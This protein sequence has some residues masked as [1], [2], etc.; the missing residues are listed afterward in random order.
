MPKRKRRNFTPSLKWKLFLKH[1]MVKVR[2]WNC[3][4][5]ITSAKN[6]SQQFLEN[7]ASLFKLSKSATERTAELEQL[8]AKLTVAVDIHKKAAT[9]LSEMGLKNDK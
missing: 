4:T 2:K 6:N 7:P 9:R 8:V 3:V 5:A 1:S